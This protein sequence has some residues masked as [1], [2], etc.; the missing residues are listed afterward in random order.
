MSHNSAAFVRQA[1][2]LA[3]T[4]FVVRLMGTLYRIP[5]TNLIGD[6]GN[7]YYVLAIQVFSNTIIL[8]HVAVKT[9]V[10]KLVSERL[11]KGERGNAHFL[12][13]TA[14]GF[15]VLA[16]LVFAALMFFFS[17]QIAAAFELPETAAA[18][19]LV[20][21][22]VV[23]VSASAVFY[24][25]FQGMGTAFPTAASQV[26]DQ[27]FKAVF[28]VALAFA[29]F[30]AARMYVP[31]AAAVSASTIGAFASFAVIFAIYMKR[32]RRMLAGAG[33]A[34]ER[35]LCQVKALL[36]AVVPIYMGIMVVSVGNLVDIR[37]LADRLTSSG[38]FGADEVRVL[39]G[40]FTGKFV[41][42]TTL[43]ASVA[44][45]V[46][47]A[48]LPEISASKTKLEPEGVRAKTDRALRLALIVAWPSAVGLS[49]LADPIL[50]LLF[51]NYPDGGILLRA[52]AYSI[53][54]MAMF[55]VTQSV[56]QGTGHVWLPA[57]SA[58]A[59]IAVKIALNH[60]L[61]FDARINITGAVV[62]TTACFIVASAMNVAF[63]KKHSGFVPN[64]REAMLKPLA[65]SALMGAAAFLA[66]AG[67][68]ALLPGQAAVAAA[69]LVGV[70]AYAFALVA[71]KG[72]EES[73]LMALPLPARLK[74]AAAAAAFGRKPPQ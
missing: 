27:L 38:A 11:A 46:A 33:P 42:L 14:M 71:L 10:V 25:Y 23:F 51:P 64:I 39:V 24:G 54:F 48:V 20:A 44:M 1:A 35:R 68:S 19:A 32:R 40:Q 9:A 74:K 43:P 70:G 6:E 26:A 58:L 4:A 30:D 34:D 29:F 61:I 2:I 28:A 47:M 65:A 18:I 45:A 7:A 57:V 50:F 59:G 73:E 36:R 21:P 69:I 37:M 12:F 13:R 31:A 15:S 66:Y 63:I 17:P 60:V 72:V 3:A 56:L 41:L 52:G 67:L 5:L 49:V 53:V 55:F 16:G 22:S 8:Q 62:S